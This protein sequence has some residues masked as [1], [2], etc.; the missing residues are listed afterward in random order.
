LREELKLVYKNKKSDGTWWMQFSDWFV[1]YSHLYVG[2]V[3]PETWE[4]YSIESIWQGK[5]A[6][7]RRLFLFIASL[8]AKNGL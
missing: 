3:F 1:Q 7:G 2:K 4:S 8:P 5:T 6:G